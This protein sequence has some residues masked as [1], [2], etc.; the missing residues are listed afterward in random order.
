MGA[1]TTVD[2]LVQDVVQGRVER[3]PA[4]HVAA[5]GHDDAG[6]APRYG[7]MTDPGI[8][9]HDQLGAID[10]RGKVISAA[11]DKVWHV[12]KREVFAVTLAS[13]RVR[14]TTARHRWYSFD[15]W[16]RLEELAPGDRVA[17]ARN[18]P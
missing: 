4:L 13:G 14:R 1:R 10:E 3:T 15:G 8:V 6:R 9:G 18:L 2:R 12:G 5:A 17:I 16:K 7:D 11:S